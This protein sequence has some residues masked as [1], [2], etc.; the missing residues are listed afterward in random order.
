MRRFLFAAAGVLALVTSAALLTR[1]AEKQPAPRQPNQVRDFM[2]AKL[3]HSERVLEGLTL[4]DFDLVAKH[5]QELSL[6]SQ[7]AQWQVLQTPEYLH[8]SQ[9]FRRIADRLTAAAREKNLDGATLAYV[10]LTM[11]CVQCH[12][13]VRGNQPPP[14]GK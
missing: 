12:R 2:R 10:E 9:E 4:Q 1:A 5:A 13:Y 7:A 14:A 8:R 11:E 3:V 6:L